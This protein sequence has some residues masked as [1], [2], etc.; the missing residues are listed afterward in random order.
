MK[1]DFFVFTSTA[2]DMEQ[3]QRQR[4]FYLR[5][6]IF[7]GAIMVF[8]LL[9][10]LFAYQHRYY[11][12]YTKVKTVNDEANDLASM[13]PYRQGFV[14]FTSNSIT[15]YK[16][17]GEKVWSNSCSAKNPIVKAAGNYVMVA[18]KGDV[19][20]SVFDKK[21]EKYALVMSHP[22]ME[23][24]VSHQGVVAVAIKAKKTN[25]I[26]MYNVYSEK[27]VSIKT[28]INENGYPLSMDLS[29]DGKTLCASYFVV[30][31]L[32]TKNRLTFYDFSEKGELT[33]HL[34]GGF[35]LDNTLVPTV[36]FVDQNTVVAFGDDRIKVYQVGN[37]IK[38]TK[39]ILMTSTV[40]SVAYDD[41]HF[42]IVR[43]RNINE[44]NGS[45]TLEV[46]SKN[47]NRVGLGGVDG[48]YSNFTLTGDTITL[49]GSYRSAIYTIRGNKIFDYKFPNKIAQIIPEGKG[50]QYFA[51]FNDRVELVKLK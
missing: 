29:P 18:D 2:Q 34:L 22:I 32:R 6:R 33:E 3:A 40:K 11:R 24:D 19:K 8:M 30:D 16:N 28:S 15:Y 4:K 38:E 50:R 47:G 14:R 31:G 35:D 5:Y 23:A 37:K 21:G 44:K 51:A 9:L 7:I 25:Y 46:F 45:F 39:E 26:E 49:T 42:A 13:V 12:D 27:L 48:D 20:M 41:E 43:E 17:N 1:E 10:A 36:T